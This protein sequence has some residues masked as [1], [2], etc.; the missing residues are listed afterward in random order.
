LIGPQRGN[1][2][3]PNQNVRQV[4]PR[5]QGKGGNLQ[6][7]DPSVAPPEF[8]EAYKEFSRK[9]SELEQAKEKK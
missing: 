9:I 3:L 8:R 6:R 2:S 1:R 5:E 4:D 7:L